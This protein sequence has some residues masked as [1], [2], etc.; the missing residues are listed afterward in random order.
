MW[1]HFEYGRHRLRIKEHHDI[2]PLIQK[3]IIDRNEENY[4]KI[5][6]SIDWNTPDKY[7]HFIGFFEACLFGSVPPIFGEPIVTIENCELRAIGDESMS[8]QGCRVCWVER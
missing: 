3:W 1:L 6:D 7:W 8:S 2:L 4:N 5:I